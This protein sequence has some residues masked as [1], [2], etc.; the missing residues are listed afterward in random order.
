MGRRAGLAGTGDLV[1]RPGWYENQGRHST[2]A[3]T[4]FEQA[5]WLAAGPSQTRL[6]ARGPSG[7]ADQ[8]GQVA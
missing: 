1:G 7:W 3:D 6:A 8:A 4:D 5:G 2:A